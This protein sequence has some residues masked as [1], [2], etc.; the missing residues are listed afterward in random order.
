MHRS[1]LLAVAA[2]RF[3][4]AHFTLQ[5]PTAIGLDDGK[6][7]TSP[8]GNSNPA[9]RSAGVSNWGI[10][11]SNVGVMSTDPSVTWELN[12]ALLSDPT[13]FVPLV[14]KFAQNGAGEICFPKIPAPAEWEG[15]DGVLQV[16]QHGPDGDLY[17]CAAIRFVPG[18]PD[19]VPAGCTNAAAVTSASTTSAGPPSS[20]SDTASSTAT[21]T[22]TATVSSSESA[23]SSSV[24]SSMSMNMSSITM[25]MTMSA[26]AS[27]TVTVSATSS[28]NASATASTSKAPA[29]GA[30]S[31]VGTMG[32]VVAVGL[33]VAAFFI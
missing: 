27:S 23:G 11:G 3:A 8:C 6:E 17:Q 33:V 25:T 22:A 28:A 31:V 15:K 30:S 29:S 13:K 24:A 2:L 10:S 18:G 19:A 14:Q 32:N 5:I 26:S 9:N 1:V 7:A 12:A 16:V 21:A 4:S 20:G